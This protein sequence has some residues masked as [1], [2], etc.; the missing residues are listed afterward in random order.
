MR[1][2]IGVV[3]AAAA[4][5]AAAGV[6]GVAAAQEPVATPATQRL[7]TVNGGSAREVASDASAAVRREAYGAALGAALDDAKAKAAFVAERSGLVLGAIHSVTEQT[8]SV[9]DGCVAFAESQRGGEARP[10]PQVR[11]PRRKRGA[12]R[13]VQEPVPPGPYRCQAVA[14]VTVS[15]A[16]AG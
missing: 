15:Y 11:R 3:L 16:V 4:A 10:L 13:T 8:G 2:W 14:S 1:R 5:L 7:V 6:L 12:A 9:L